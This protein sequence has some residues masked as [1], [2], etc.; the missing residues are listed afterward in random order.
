MEFSKAMDSVP[1]N[2]SRRGMSVRDL[3]DS[4]AHRYDSVV[5]ATG[6]IGP[7]WLE[8]NLSQVGSPSRVI[9]MGCANGALGA[10]LRGRFP[11]A[12]ITGLDISERMIEEARIREV[13]DRLIVHDLNVPLV[14]IEDSS[15]DLVVALGFC[16]FL[17][18]PELLLGE[19]S[20]VLSVGGELFLSFQEFWP[21]RPTA[22]PRTTRSGSV[23]HK[24][25]TV[26]EVSEMLEVQPLSTKKLVSETGYVSGSGFACPYVFVH[27]V[28]EPG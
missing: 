11:E 8:R 27:A 6:Y 28:R 10:V 15:A 16:E 1:P 25:Y 18:E 26:L 2:S 13:Y 3:Y 12:C 17:A 9:D 21:D 23:L 20:R 7:N 5:E 4:M 24:A 22:A 14:Q 19:I